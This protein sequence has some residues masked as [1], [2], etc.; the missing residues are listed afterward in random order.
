MTGL[1]RSFCCALMLGLVLAPLDAEAKRFGGGGSLGKS[2][3]TQKK[4]APAA[5]PRPSST[6]QA[7]TG[8]QQKTAAARPG[9]GGM[10]GGLLAGSLLGAL[11]FGG[12]FD[13]IQLMDVLIIALIGFVLFKLFA[14]S[15]PVR[16]QP[17]YAGH[18][19]GEQ[20]MA[21]QTAEPLSGG[22]F[23]PTPLM[24]ARFDESEVELPGWFNKDAFIEGARQH[25]AELQRAWSINDL[26][27]IETYCSAEL[28]ADL[29]AER[30]RLGAA[31]LDND[32]VSV[33]ADIVGY[34]EANQE[35]RLS[36]NFYGW[37]R[38]GAGND[39]TEFN[40]I[41]HLT[42]DLTRADADWFIVGIE[43]P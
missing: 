29:V 20:P 16:P 32:L 19:G 33:M 31:T 28:Y 6:Q 11:F 26:S 8:S 15:Q 25:F 17:S 23:E 21:R 24:S 42:R 43:Q 39:T 4:A 3:F 40:E 41:W 7:A 9:M 10:L 34:S 1:L 5:A 27:T 18:A 14:R 2:F 12:A 22:S 36:I 37:M 30:E 13:G 35:A 38:E